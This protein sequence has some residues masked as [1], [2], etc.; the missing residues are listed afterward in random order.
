MNE[1][2]KGKELHEALTII[3]Q[4]KV[5]VVEN[6]LIIGQ[7]LNSLSESGLWKSAGDHIKN[8]YDFLKEIRIGRSTAYNCMKIAKDFGELLKSNKLDSIPEYTRLVSLLPVSTE[9][10]KKE[11]LIKAGTLTADDFDDEIREAKGR[12]PR[13]QCEHKNSEPW[14]KCSECGKF[15]RGGGQ[16]E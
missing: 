3:S 12:T 10:T 8:F 14:K 15:L 4:A 2:T 5:N 9:E 11:W 13:G 16:G 6:F 1:L 7:T